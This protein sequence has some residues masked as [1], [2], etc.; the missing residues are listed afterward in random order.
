ML[1][2]KKIVSKIRNMICCAKIYEA[3]S[4]QCRELNNNIIKK[5]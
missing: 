4:V 2:E 1:I 3:K 5:K